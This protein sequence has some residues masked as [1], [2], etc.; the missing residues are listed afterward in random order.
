MGVLL[1]PPSRSC[2]QVQVPVGATSWGSLPTLSSTL[3]SNLDTSSMHPRR[4]KYQGG[5]GNTTRNRDK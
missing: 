1:T 3:V 5:V 4:A 2:V